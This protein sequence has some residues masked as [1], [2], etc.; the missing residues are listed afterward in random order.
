MYVGKT[1]FIISSKWFSGHFCW[2][3]SIKKK[4]GL[5]VY[6]PSYV[7]IPGELSMKKVKVQRY[8]SGKRPE[9]AP[10]S[11]DEEETDDEDFTHP[12]VPQQPSSPPHKTLTEAELQDPRLR[13]LRAV[14]EDVTDT[15]TTTDIPESKEKMEVEEE[16]AEEKTVKRVIHQVRIFK[17]Y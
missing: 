2:I 4:K 16:E 11:S 1:F 13:R 3:I 7:Y 17:F 12:R 9:Y 8:V 5:Y 10:A 14:K 6:E 15:T